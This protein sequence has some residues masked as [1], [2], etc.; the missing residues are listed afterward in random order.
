MNTVMRL[1]TCIRALGLRNGLRY[2]RIQ[3][4]C[5]RRPE[6]ALEWADNCEEEGNRSYVRGD[7]KGAL[8]M[9]GWAEG[10][11]ASHYAYVERG[12]TTEEGPVWL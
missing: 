11:R 12:D 2:W 6:R 5:I 9:W 3:N 4:A 8:V 7:L 10:V 1:I